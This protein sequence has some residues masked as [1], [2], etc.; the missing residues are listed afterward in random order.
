[1]AYLTFGAEVGGAGSHP[2]GRATSS[3]PLV[4]LVHQL[5]ADRG[6][7]VQWGRPLEIISGVEPVQHDAGRAGVDVA[8]E[9]LHQGARV[10]AQLLA[11]APCARALGVVNALVCMQL[12]TVP[13]HPAA[14]NC[15]PVETVRQHCCPC[16]RD[17]RGGLDVGPAWLMQLCLPRAILVL[18]R[19]IMCLLHAARVWEAR[20]GQP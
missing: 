20:P 15:G 17:L 5:I 12:V 6:A 10:V 8:N 3:E 9:E 7:L 13:V 14:G 16:L 11:C 19:F 18:V 2:R 1:M 4:L